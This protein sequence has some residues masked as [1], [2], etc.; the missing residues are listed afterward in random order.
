MVALTGGLAMENARDG[1]MDFFIVTAPGRLWLVRG[2]TV[3]LV[4]A[5]RLFGDRLC[6]NFFLT[7]KVLAL[8]DQNL[9]TAHEI[10]QMIPLY[11]S[12]VYCQV[13]ALNRWTDDFLPNADGTAAP[14]IEK[15]LNR[16]GVWLKRA[17]ERLLAGRIGDRIERW[18]MTRKIAKLSAQAPANANEIVFSAD[19]CR[20]FFNGYGSRTL[21]DFYQRTGELKVP[22]DK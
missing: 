15:P 19:T 7:E 14:G 21:A 1:D 18:E 12:H 9:Y 16:P 2:L 17:G 4:R 22:Q 5:A 6:P 11:G 10:A 13:R 20:G 8:R 3:A